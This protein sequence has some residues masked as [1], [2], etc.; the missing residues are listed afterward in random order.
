MTTQAT[1]SR[2]EFRKAHTWNTRT[3]KD[4]W[5]YRAVVNEIEGRHSIGF[6]LVDPDNPKSLRGRKPPREPVRMLDRLQQGMTYTERDR[7][8][9]ELVWV[10]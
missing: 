8:D 3:S 1:V 4:A 5:K 9:I 10:E 2:A 6:V 7:R